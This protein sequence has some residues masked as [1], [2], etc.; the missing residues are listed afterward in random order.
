MKSTTTNI[1]RK[2]PAAPHKRQSF[3]RLL[4]LNRP[5][6]RRI[7]L[8]SLCVL[9]VNGALLIKPYILKVVI[10]NFLTRHAAQHGLYSLTAMGVLYFVVVLLSGFFGVAQVN[11][12]NT[13]GQEIMRS[14]RGRVFRTIQFLPLNFLDKTS[15][16]SLITRATNDV[17]ALSELYTDVLI[18]L[19]QDVFLI[20]GIVAAMLM[21]DVRLTLVSF[22][23]IPVMLTVIFLMR[24]RVKRCFKEM[25]A[26]IGRINGFMAENLAGMKIVQIFHGEEEKKRE[27]RALN[28]E[29]YRVTN[30]QVRLNSILKP[31][32]AV[33]Q[34]LA[35][36]L[37]I[38][39]G[40]GKIAA[41]TLQIGVLYAFTTYIR[42]FFDPVSDLADNYT[43][44]QSAFVSA[45]RI[46]ELLDQKDNLEDLD[47]GTAMERIEG[48]IEFKH[49]WFAYNGEDWVLRDV[50]FRVP[51]GHTAA[52]VGETGAGKTTIISL[53]SGFY[54]AQKGQILI[55]GV[56]IRDIRKRDL[57]RNIAV[58]LQDVFLFSDTISGN[59]TLNDP[60][61]AETAERAVDAACAREFVN[62]LPG[63]LQE[64]VM[65]RGNTLSAGQRQLVSFARAIAHDPAVIVLDEATANIDSRTEILIQRAIENMA[66]DRTALIIAHRLSTIRGADRIIVLRHG[67]IVETG[68]HEELMAMGGYYSHMEQ[69]GVAGE[70]ALPATGS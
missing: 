8:A 11:L 55:D 54:T 40:M 29:Y 53:I 42:Q 59:I 2:P 6:L 9:L 12:I 19:F 14:L 47:R 69:E 50:S 31:A 52:F 23:V 58:V 62:S 15:S 16:G 51:K 57:R 49:V 25:K 60:I 45:D 68:T 46:F 5:Q 18:S 13:A 41:G 21:M 63:G 48:R 1:G 36:A 22:C 65:E 70:S 27:F 7:V 32:A 3:R 20:L 28:G 61:P 37:L 67:R 43:N 17:E 35:I 34:N 10:D 39:Y 38:W 4:G 24:S 26:L 33:F 64:P 66:Q 30:F 44:I 56:D